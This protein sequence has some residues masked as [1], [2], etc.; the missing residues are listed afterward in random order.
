MKA[1]RETR[2]GAEGRG[3]ESL[4]PDHSNQSNS[5]ISANS[6][7]RPYPV[8]CE[9]RVLTTQ[10]HR[11]PIGKFQVST[12]VI[13]LAGPLRKLYCASNSAGVVPMP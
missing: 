12:L 2:L 10:L 4:R 8:A 7:S 6:G 1:I 5:E 9:R 11:V 13:E 3:F